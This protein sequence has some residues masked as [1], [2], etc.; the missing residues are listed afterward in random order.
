M[1][2]LPDVGKQLRSRIVGEGE[3][4]PEQL[5]ANPQNWRT[6]PAAQVEALEGLLRQV[7]WV[8]RVIV[9]RT[10]G[11]IVDGHARVELAARRG[12]RSVPVVYVDLSE[13]EERLVLAAL[14]PLGALATTDTAQLDALLDTVSADDA[15]LQAVLDDMLR[16]DIDDDP[17]A[18]A[19]HTIER[20]DPE[21]DGADE[22]GEQRPARNVYPLVL[23]LNRAQYERWRELK[24][25][26]AI[27]DDAAM[28]AK[29]MGTPQ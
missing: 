25:A 7:G 16:G 29:L 24:A 1:S 9:N 19:A 20:E 8:Q 10:T 2:A 23:A 28:L 4:A 17:E 6:H 15:A 11:H 12:E 3:V 13:D 5:R 27:T 26:H 22:G 21:S 14:D 18:L